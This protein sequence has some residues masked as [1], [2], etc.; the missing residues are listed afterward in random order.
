MAAG[1]SGHIVEEFENAFQACFAAL[2]SQDHFNIHDSE[3]VRTGVEQSLQKFLDLAKQVECF[4]L[5]KRLQLAVQRPEQILKEDINELRQELARKDQLIQKHYEKIAYWQGLLADPPGVGRPSAQTPPAA[6]TR[7]S[8]TT[9][10]HSIPPTPTFSPQQQ[11]S[12]QPS[13]TTSIADAGLAGPL[14]YLEKTTS[15]IGLPERR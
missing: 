3:E 6:V 13:T 9:S 10:H 11:I 7:P 15:N 2:T 12:S 8:P 14:A 4:F 5:Q 1:H